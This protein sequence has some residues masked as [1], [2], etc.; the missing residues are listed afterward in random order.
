MDTFWSDLQADDIEVEDIEL[1]EDE[2][3]RLFSGER[4]PGPVND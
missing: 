3:K 4:T 2:F 1:L